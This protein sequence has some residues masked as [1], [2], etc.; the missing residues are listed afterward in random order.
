MVSYPKGSDSSGCPR[1]M[2]GVNVDIYLSSRVRPF[3]EGRSL[4]RRRRPSLPS[5]RQ[6]S[7]PS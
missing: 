3:P 4:S 7:R 2:L 6:P 1:P 5:W